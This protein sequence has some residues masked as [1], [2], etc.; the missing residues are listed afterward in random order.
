MSILKPST[1]KISGRVSIPLNKEVIQ[2]KDFVPKDIGF[3]DNK[4]PMEQVG[5][6]MNNN[7]PV[8]LVGETGTGK[9][10][11][12]RHLACRTHNAFVRVNHNGGTSVEDIVGRWLINE[13]G[14]H[15]VDG[16]LI[17]AMKKGH[18]YLAD[19]INAASAEINF[20]YH[21]LL[22]DDGR[23]VLVEKDHEV[24]IPH[25]NFRFFGAMNPPTE[26]AGTKELN[27]ALLSRFAVVK[28]D[29]VPPK[30]EAKIL[31]E[32]TG[33]DQAVADKMVA[34]ASQIRMAHVKQKVRFVIS[35]RELLMWAQMYKVYG[36]FINAAESSIMNKVNEEDIAAITDTLGL[37]FKSMDG[38]AKGATATPT[39]EP[40]KTGAVSSQNLSS[41]E[42]GNLTGIIRQMSGSAPGTQNSW[43]VKTGVWTAA[44]LPNGELHVDFNGTEIDIEPALLVN[45]QNI[46]LIQQQQTAQQFQNASYVSANTVTS[47]INAIK[48][49]GS[50][51]GNSIKKP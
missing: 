47:A 44:I 39:P 28:I 46:V 18:W 3:E 42:M 35:T 16:I 19:E 12:V 33:I 51:Y 48:K 6:A 43:P 2:N 37:H 25:K 30:V 27:K 15:W 14:T 41:Q 45:Y 22:D 34:F 50:N 23:V 17:D 5:I 9:T 24:I 4:I 31:V 1:F 11:L 8:L 7:L 29:F 13:K 40:T 10:S 21:S 26:Y 36:K 20:V 49:Y 32:R 38:M